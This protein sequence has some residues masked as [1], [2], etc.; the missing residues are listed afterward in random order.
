MKY[1]FLSEKFYETYD[2]VSYPE[3]E[4]KPDRPYIMIKICINGVDFA[5]PLRSDISHN[6]VF[7]TDKPNKCGVDYSKV[8]VIPDLTYIDTRKP[9]IRPNEHKR[10]MGKDFILQKGLEKYIK[11]YKEALRHININKN[12][13]LCKFSTL[14]YFHKEINII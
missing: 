7:W 8:V 13:I 5:V 4:R 6:H 10:L 11:E 14:Q 1:I 3:I 9:Y 12:K 2:Q